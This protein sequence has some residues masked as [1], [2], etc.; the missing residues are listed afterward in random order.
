MLRSSKKWEQAYSWVQQS[1]SS[2]LHL[3]HD[4]LPVIG[5]AK[6]CSS[7]YPECVTETSWVEKTVYDGSIAFNPN[8]LTN[9]RV[10]LA[11]RQE[12]AQSLF[13]TSSQHPYGHESAAWV[14][15]QWHKLVCYCIAHR[16]S[17]THFHFS[18]NGCDICVHL[19]II[20]DTTITIANNVRC[21][22]SHAKI[23]VA[24][25][26]IG[27]HNL[28]MQTF[29]K[30]GQTVEVNTSLANQMSYFV[31]DKHGS[32]E[33]KAMISGTVGLHAPDFLQVSRH[34]SA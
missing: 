14:P 28:K 15:G 17:I 27:L 18:E 11:Q 7:G 22:Y 6:C 26:D 33:P 5:A 10:L 16:D 4:I 31:R 13:T 1:I 3:L 21:F 25:N 2:P 32:N 23:S 30:L 20:K 8:S 19:K 12:K 9:Y 24:V 34:Y 29:L